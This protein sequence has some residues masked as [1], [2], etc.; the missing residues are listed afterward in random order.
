M[1]LRQPIPAPRRSAS[2]DALG[3]LLADDRGATAIEYGLIAALMAL[4]IVAGLQALGGE[5]GALY[6]VL[7]EI[8][9]AI[10]ARLST[11]TPGASQATPPPSRKYAGANTAV[12]MDASEE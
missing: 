10:A 3:G 1:A 8:S 7:D 9:T 6:T 12:T 11:I 2:R 5:T 4:V